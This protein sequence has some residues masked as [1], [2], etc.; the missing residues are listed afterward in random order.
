VQAEAHYQQAL[1]VGEE[2]GMRPLVAHCH[3]GLGQLYATVGCRA[4][5]RA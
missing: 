1:I 2:L 4:E 3:H 5:A